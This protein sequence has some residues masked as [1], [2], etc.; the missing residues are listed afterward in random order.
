MG[1]VH[2]GLPQQPGLLRVAE[3]VIVTSIRLFS[4]LESHSP[5]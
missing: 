1:V 4:P 5:S 3:A 2:V